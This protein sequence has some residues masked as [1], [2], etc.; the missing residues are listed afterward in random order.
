MDTADA[1]ASLGSDGIIDS[2]PI[3]APMIQSTPANEKSSKAESPVQSKITVSVFCFVLRNMNKE[4][5]N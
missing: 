4:K 2:H 5:F 1:Q 3:A